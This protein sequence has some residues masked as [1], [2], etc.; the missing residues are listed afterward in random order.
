VGLF[1]IAWAE[2]PAAVDRRFSDLTI[3]EFG[4]KLIGTM[5]AESSRRLIDTTDAELLR[6]ESEYLFDDFDRAVTRVVRRLSIP[7]DASLRAVAERNLDG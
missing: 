2:S 5:N 7:D 3:R 6:P 1:T 4:L